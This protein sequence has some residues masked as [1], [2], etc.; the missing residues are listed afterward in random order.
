MDIR[1]I[2]WL[3]ILV[4]T[5]S[6]IL[7]I[8]VVLTKKGKFLYKHKILS[9]I[10]FIIVNI[11]LLNIYLSNQRLNLSYSHGILGFLF[12][13]FSILNLILGFLYTGK[14]KPKTK[15]ILRIIHIWLGR[16]SFIILLL[17]IYFGYVIFKPF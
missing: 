9:T 10:G 6:F 16:I 4:G 3:F 1:V 5:I 17:N 13:V 14:A 7:S 12:F 11:S 8:I 15:K 2:H